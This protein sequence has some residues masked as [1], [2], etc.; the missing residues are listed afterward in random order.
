MDSNLESLKKTNYNSEESFED[1]NFIKKPKKFQS[2]RMKVE[3][4]SEEKDRLDIESPMNLK[5]NPK[6]LILESKTRLLSV[7]SPYRE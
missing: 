5:V 3:K 2:P 7:L 6:N 1:Y 4:V